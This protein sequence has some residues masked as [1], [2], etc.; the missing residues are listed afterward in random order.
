M[1]RMS[2]ALAGTIVR[3]SAT[4]VLLAKRMP[5]EVHAK[6]KAMHVI[7]VVLILL[8]RV[9]TGTVRRSAAKII[10]AKLK[11][12]KTHVTVKTRKNLAVVLSLNLNHV[13]IATSLSVK[14]SA[15]RI[16]G[17]KLKPAK[18]RVEGLPC[19]KPVVVLVR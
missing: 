16:C 5:A 1:D 12:A 4:S 13:V 6:V 7:A 8:M 15:T 10:L 17:V 2:R 11:P 14:I 9:G 3:V 18:R 19:K